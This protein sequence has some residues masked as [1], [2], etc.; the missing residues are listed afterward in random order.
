MHFYALLCQNESIVIKRCKYN[1]R[2]FVAVGKNECK[3]SISLNL[4][5]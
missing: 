2:I 5:F 1:I 3:Y 4:Q